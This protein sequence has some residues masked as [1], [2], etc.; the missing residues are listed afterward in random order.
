PGTAVP[1]AS[2]LARPAGPSAGGTWEEDDDDIIYDDAFFQELDRVVESAT[3]AGA[4]GPGGDMARAQVAGLATAPT[5]VSASDG[6]P[7]SAAGGAVP[8]GVD[9]GAPN[10]RTAVG[11]CC[12]RPAFA[13]RFVPLFNTP[14]EA[15]DE[16]VGE[17]PGCEGI[18]GNENR[19]TAGGTGTGAMAVAM[20]CSYRTA[21][22]LLAAT[23]HTTHAVGVSAVGQAGSYGASWMGHASPHPP[24]TVAQPSGTATIPAYTSHNR[25]STNT[26]GN[27]A[28]AG[29]PAVAMPGGSSS[30]SIP[31]AHIQ[32]QNANYHREEE[33]KKEGKEEEGDDGEDVAVTICDM[34]DRAQMMTTPLCSVGAARSG[35]GGNSHQCHRGPPSS[36]A[37]MSGQVQLTAPRECQRTHNWA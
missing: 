22:E 24:V 31:A 12:S 18:R 3:N 27:G 8:P 2:I 6:L 34:D 29:I 30:N 37:S 5:V 1:P 11:I 33:G 16:D 9:L 10:S 36:L 13:S 17:A 28:P 32:I 26:Y 4:T 20:A 23:V 21:A 19:I 14:M 25:A 15:H 35:F 7:P